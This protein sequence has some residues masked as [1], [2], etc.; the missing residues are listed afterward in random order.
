MEPVAVNGTTAGSSRQVRTSFLFAKFLFRWRFLCFLFLLF[1][2][3]PPFPV[4][5]IPWKKL[6][7]TRTRVV[8][9][10]HF[11]SMSSSSCL[12]HFCTPSLR[13]VLSCEVYFPGSELRLRF[14][15]KNY[16]HPL[17]EFVFY[18]TRGSSFL[19][20]VKMQE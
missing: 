11:P 10:R 1:F 3:F 14:T 20:F 7:S 18:K 5:R 9:R 12:L 8:R 16:S 6:R 15:H 13:L 19:H 17:L 4:T 2:C